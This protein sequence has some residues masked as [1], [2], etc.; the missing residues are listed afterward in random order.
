MK[1]AQVTVKSTFV[2]ASV[3][4]EHVWLKRGRFAGVVTMAHVA[5]ASVMLRDRKMR[6]ASR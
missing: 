6:E 5:E 2:I 1:D 4:G 3:D